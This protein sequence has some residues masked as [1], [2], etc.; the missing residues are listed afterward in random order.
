MLTG[1]RLFQRSAHPVAA[2]GLAVP[3][4]SEYQVHQTADG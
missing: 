2:R 3:L 4:I 1:T